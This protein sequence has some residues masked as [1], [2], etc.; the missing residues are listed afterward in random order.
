MPSAYTAAVSDGI[1]FKTFVLRCA[2][3]MGA[4]VSMRD[5]SLDVPI[6]ERFEPSD[7]HLRKTL[8]AEA[9]LDTL[10]AMSPAEAETAAAAE[11]AEKVAANSTAIEK[12]KELKSR[13]LDLLRQVDS[14]NPPTVEHDEFKDF[15]SKQLTESLRFDCMDDWYVR[16]APK[17]KNGSEWLSEKMSEARQQIGYHATE[18]ENEVSRTN[19]RNQWIAELR[20]SLEEA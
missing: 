5:D 11:Y 18:Y 8:E 14:W 7:Y 9:R 3:A 2:R 10:R 13:Y 20:K 19:K 1:D 16:N 6:P 17:L 4:C 15:M 12:A